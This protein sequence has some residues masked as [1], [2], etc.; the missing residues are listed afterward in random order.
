MI[1][2][3]VLS[4]NYYYYYYGST[5]FCWALVSFWVSWSFTQ[6]LGLLGRGISP[7]HGRYLHTEQHKH[8]IKAH[9]T[10]IHALGRIRTHDPSVLARE[11]S[12][13]LRSRGY[14]DVRKH[15][16]M[17]DLWWTK[18]ALG[19]VFS[20]N[21]GFPCQSTFHLLSTF[22]FTITRG[23]QNRPGGAAVPIASQIK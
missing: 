16:G 4:I 7:S 14:W 3:Y 6:S 20:E 21:F 2:N 23:W 5:A 12:S 10:D 9:N 8:R 19:Q 17:W 15:C 18:V 11:D 13:C 22:I 1:S